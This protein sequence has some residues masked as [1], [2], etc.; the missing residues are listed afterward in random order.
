MEFYGVTLSLSMSS[1]MKPEFLGWGMLHLEQLRGKKHPWQKLLPARSV[2][3][4][5]NPWLTI[6]LSEAP[7]C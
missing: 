7:Q 4:Q 2:I 3:D 6:S 5:C 1:V